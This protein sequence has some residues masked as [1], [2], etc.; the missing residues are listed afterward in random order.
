MIIT[1]P[2]NPY[3]CRLDYFYRYTTKQSSWLRGGS[4]S[5]TRRRLIVKDYLCWLATPGPYSKN[6]K[7]PAILSDIEKLISK[8]PNFQ[9]RNSG[10][11]LIRFQTFNLNQ[12][13]QSNKLIAIA[14]G[15]S[16]ENYRG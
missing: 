4:N 13:I 10:P 6:R 3:E 8:H 5:Y 1:I 12:V 16:A 2:D 14:A 7:K 9:W 15:N 11:L